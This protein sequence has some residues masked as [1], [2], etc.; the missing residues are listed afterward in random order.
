[1]EPVLQRTLKRLFSG[2]RLKTL[3]R[4]DTCKSLLLTTHKVEVFIQ[5][6]NSFEPRHSRGFS[7]YKKINRITMRFI[8]TMVEVTGLEPAASCSQSRRATTCATPR[9]CLFNFIC[10]SYYQLCFVRPLAVPVISSAC[11]KP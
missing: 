8:K 10:F 7:L 2:I 6:L 11:T 3:I 5:R 9:Y 4:S 1:M